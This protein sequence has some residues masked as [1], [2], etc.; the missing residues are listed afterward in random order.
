MATR[1]SG[2]MPR[3]SAIS[4]SPRLRPL[5]S[6]RPTKSGNSS[7]QAW[8]FPPK[9][10]LLLA[11][12]IGP[13]NPR[14]SQLGSE[15]LREGERVSAADPE[16]GA[17]GPGVTRGTVGLIRR[18]VEEVVDTE[19]ERAGADPLGLAG[20]AVAD[21]PVQLQLILTLFHVRC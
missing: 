14:N 5:R 9:T 7:N 19:A 15:L 10:P 2:R 21:R 17:R 1:R 8:S 18:V 16:T 4:S 12:S 3:F 13:S 20:E 6:D 11:S